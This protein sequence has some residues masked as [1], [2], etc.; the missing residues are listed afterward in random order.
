M[1]GGRSSNQHI[2]RQRREAERRRKAEVKRQ[3]RLEKGPKSA[4]GDLLEAEHKEESPREA[5]LPLS[6]GPGVEPTNPPANTVAPEQARLRWILKALND[7]AGLTPG[8]GELLATAAEYLEGKGVLRA[9]QR[10][11]LEKLYRERG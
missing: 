10:K 11:Q 6:Q 4:P 3:R 1:A 9:P 7:S 8:E 2:Q 5:P